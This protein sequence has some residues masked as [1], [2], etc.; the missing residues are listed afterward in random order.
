MDNSIA[1]VK[2]KIARLYRE[3][4]SNIIGLSPRSKISLAINLFALYLILGAIALADRSR[5]PS[6]WLFFPPAT[7]P[8]PLAG[9]LTHTFQL[10]GCVPSI[11][12]LFTVS[13]LY[14]Q[15]KHGQNGLFLLA[16]ALVTSIFAINEVYRGHIILLYYDIPKDQTIGVFAIGVILYG[17]IFWRQIRETSYPILLGAL[18][19][20]ALA[21][22]MDFARLN[23]PEWAALAEGIPKLLSGLN[24][25]LYFW[26]LCSR[27]LSRAIA[28]E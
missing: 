3:I 19:L 28:Q 2:T 21:I 15:K 10:L 16:S 27:E 26:D 20:L 24:F 23:H 12:C 17:L 11:V 7:P 13:V 6:S 25:T 9:L 4:V 5:I 18:A 22:G 8:A 1:G 14:S